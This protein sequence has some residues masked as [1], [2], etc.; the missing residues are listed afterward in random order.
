MNKLGSIF[1]L[2]A[3]GLAAA[4]APAGGQSRGSEPL[5]GTRSGEAGKILAAQVRLDRAGF[6]PGEID[7]RNG[8]NTK[9]AL[10]A[11]QRARGLEPTGTLSDATI[12][13]L[14][15]DAEDVLTSY[16][17][18]AD[19]LAR[20]FVEEVPAD[21]MAQAELPALSY[22]S[23]LEMLGE[24]FHASPELLQR[25]NPD[26][27]FTTAGEELRVPAVAAPPAPARDVVP[28]SGTS[29]TADAVVI[30]SKA[31]S[32]L[33]V[34]ADGRVVLHAPVTVGSEHDP[35]P[36]GEWAVTGVHR[37]PVFHYNPDLFWDAD[38]SHAK[39]KIQPGPNN[40]VG[41]M[42]I[43]LTREHYGLHGTPEPGK[44]GHTASHGCVRLTNWDVERVAAFVRNGTPVVFKE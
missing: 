43:D 38:P 6:S 39:A 5:R 1:F 26:A 13:A 21:L 29:E 32:A 25:L 27:T 30:V 37:N 20:P 24:R 14:G 2:M 4:T 10:K 17:L 40:P 36:I 3:C 18:T 35:L 41:V 8:A 23:A 16:V 22:R 11:F 9:R 31:E 34:E 12:E 42:W 44:V 7:G 15:A 33:V 28:T 19:D